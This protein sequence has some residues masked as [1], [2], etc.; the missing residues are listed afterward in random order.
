MLENVWYLLGILF[1]VGIGLFRY[2]YLEEFKTEWEAQTL[3]SKLRDH[4]KEVRLTVTCGSRGP[5]STS[6]LLSS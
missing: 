6:G 1:V 5:Y 2:V 3:Q 4:H